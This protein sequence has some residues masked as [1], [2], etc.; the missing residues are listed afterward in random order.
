QSGLTMLKEPLQIYSGSSS[1]TFNSFF[2]N[3]AMLYNILVSAPN[4]NGYG[5][6]KLYNP[7]QA[8]PTTIT[9]G[10]ADL[11]VR[12]VGTSANQV[13][14]SRTEC[15]TG[16]AG[17]VGAIYSGNNYGVNIVGWRR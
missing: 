4:S 15:S 16:S 2:R 11:T 5:Y 17:T 13:G 10:N 7:N 14:T 9:N 1:T 3:K 12:T 8:V 6:V